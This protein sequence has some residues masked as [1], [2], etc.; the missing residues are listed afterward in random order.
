MVTSM[1]ESETIAEYL[2]SPA[3]RCTPLSLQE[4]EEEYLLAA[5]RTKDGIDKAEYEKR[6]GH[7]FSSVY[8]DAISR[9]D[10]DSYIDSNESFALTEKGFMTLDWIILEMA[11]G[12]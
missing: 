6:F 1:R 8:S 7:S 3:L 5:L 10:K 4:T 9:I 12:L 11:M 2:S